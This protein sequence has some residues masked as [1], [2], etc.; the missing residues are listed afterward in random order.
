MAAALLL[1]GCGQAG[2]GDDADPAAPPVSPAEAMKRWVDG[3]TDGRTRIPCAM[4]RDAP[5]AEDCRIETVEDAQGRVFILSRPDGGFR[6]VRL[7]ADG[8][9]AAADGAIEPRTAR[10]GS[11]VA[12][13]FGEERYA[14]PVSALEGGRAP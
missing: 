9:L 6:R 7:D 10:S 8:T 4:G 13:L 14:L 2:P 3:A 12:I 1:G 5:L 11:A